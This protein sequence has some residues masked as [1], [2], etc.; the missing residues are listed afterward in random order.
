MRVDPEMSKLLEEYNVTFKGEVQSTF[1]ATFV[2]VFSR[3]PV[4]RGLVLFDETDG[5][6]TTRI[7]DPG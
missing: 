2:L 5:R 7:H 1:V 6:P 3:P 4:F